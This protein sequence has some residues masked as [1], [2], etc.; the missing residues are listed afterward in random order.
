MTRNRNPENDLLRGLGVIVA[1]VAVWM[2]RGVALAQEMPVP[3]CEGQPYPAAGV[4]GEL[5]NQ[6]VLIE[7]QV[8]EGWTP[9]EC[10]GW[11]AGPTKALQA[12]AGRFRMAG[13]TD[14]LATHLARVSRMASIDYWSTT[15]ARWRPLFD[16]AFALTQPDPN[17]RRGDFT[18]DDVVPG[19]ELYSWLKEN[20]P[21]AGIVYRTKVHERTPDRL[22]YETVNVTA[23][24]AKLLLFTRKIAGPEEFRQLYFVEREQDDI[25]HFYSLNR[26][27][28]ARTFSGTSAASF[29]NRAEAYFRYLAAL[30][31]TREPPAS[32]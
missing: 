11:S 27:G 22:V 7:E 16:E 15:R 29:R 13:D 3:P 12:T 10:T 17:A 1:M 25:W 20:N 28:Q 26:M 8:P 14:A 2:S 23:I 30:E 21:T 6:L 9:P 24:E 32:P 31:M 4:V 5:L 19:A 18:K